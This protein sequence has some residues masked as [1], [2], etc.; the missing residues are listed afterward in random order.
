[1]QGC[2]PQRVMADA[3]RLGQEHAWLPC[4]ERDSQWMSVHLLQGTTP[5]TSYLS[6]KHI[7]HPL[8][9]FLVL[10]YLPSHL[11]LIHLTH[12]ILPSCPQ[13]LTS[14]L[15]TYLLRFL[16]PSLPI[17]HLSP[18]ISFHPQNRPSSCPSSQPSMQVDHTLPVHPCNT[19]SQYTL[20]IH[21][22][23]TPFQYTLSIH[24]LDTH[25]QYTLSIHP[26]NPPSRHTL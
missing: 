18:S 26:L 3:R 4:V 11:L 15:T 14:L 20:A 6:M 10:S 7:Y 5:P 25:F 13:Y 24:P 1:M 9:Q 23:N 16:F 19:P 8:I 21:P 22:L 17:S 2:L 12:T